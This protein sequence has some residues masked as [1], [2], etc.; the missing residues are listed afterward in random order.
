MKLIIRLKIKE[1]RQMIKE[2]TVYTV[3]CDRCGKDS[4][5]NGEHVGWVGKQNAI[6]IAIDYNYFIDVDGKH[7]CDDCYYYDDE[8]NLIIKQ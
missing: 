6:D 7:Y 2:I 3:I 8:D 5:D 1:I 4:N